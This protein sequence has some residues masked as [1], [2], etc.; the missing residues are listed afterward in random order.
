MCYA[1]LHAKTGLSSG[2]R[3]TATVSWAYSASQIAQ[4]IR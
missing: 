1:C 4:V 2:D 3:N